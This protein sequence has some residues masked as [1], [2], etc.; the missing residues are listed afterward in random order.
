MNSPVTLITHS[1]T[2]GGV[3]QERR[4]PAITL[5]R[6]D[7]DAFWAS[8]GYEQAEAFPSGRHPD[9]LSPAEGETFGLLKVPKRRRD[10][11]AGRY[12]AKWA[13]RGQTGRQDL[14]WE[15]I[16]IR[17]V[18]G[19]PEH[20]RP[21]VFID[22]E[23]APVEISISHSGRIALAC[24]VT[25]WD[26]RVGIDVEQI[27]EREEGFEA[28]ALTPEERR[29]LADW[30][31][32]GRAEAVTQHWALKEAWLKAVGTGLRACLTDLD[33]FARLESAA[34][35]GMQSQDG[36]VYAWVALKAT[37]GNAGAGRI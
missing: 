1:E 34:G 16:E 21:R 3:M 4:V 9:W 7:I 26:L 22:G 28:L 8:G 2:R 30:T 17:A 13:V 14:A 10:W 5:Y 23:A 12:V 20:G 27:A 11:L 29:A 37:Q 6:L 15:R 35:W 25:M 33:I 18:Q 31:G 24:A 36:S 19:G 32:P